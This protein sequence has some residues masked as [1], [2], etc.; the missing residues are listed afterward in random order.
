MTLLRQPLSF[1]IGPEQMLLPGKTDLRTQF[2]ALCYRT[3]K[4][5]TE[6]LLVTSRRSARWILPKGWPMAG[7]RPPKVA[8]REAWEEAGVKGDPIDHCLGLYSY[9]KL[10]AQGTALPCVALVYPVKVKS[11]A[12]DWPEYGQRRRKW[13]SPKKAAQQVDS[14]ELARLLKRFDPRRLRA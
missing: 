7:R 1:P 4:G 9:A 3:Q 5:K 10:T 12:A 6:I 14:P 11:L 2:A 8:L 13:F